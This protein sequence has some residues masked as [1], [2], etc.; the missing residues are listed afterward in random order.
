MAIP[1][2]TQASPVFDLACDWV[3]QLCFV[4]K[5]FPTAVHQRHTMQAEGRKL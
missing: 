5:S 4:G 1:S 3:T 2:W